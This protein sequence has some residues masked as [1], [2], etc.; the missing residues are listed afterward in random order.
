MPDLHKPRV[1]VVDD[2][3]LIREGVARAIRRRVPGAVVVPADTAPAAIAAVEREA[4]SM[5]VL[6]LGLPGGGGEWGT[7]QRLRELR[8]ALPILVLSMFPEEK[9]G[10]AAIERGASGY[11]CKTADRATVGE[12][13]LAVLAGRG[14]RSANLQSLLD[15]GGTSKAGGVAALSP[16]EL[17]VL[18]AL[19]QGD[20]N[21]EIA[22]RLGVGVTTVATYRA[23]IME[24]LKLNSAVELVRYVVE[25]RLV[26]K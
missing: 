2:H 20:A 24:K 19:G 13:A 17:E 8:P 3:A 6:D 1:L 12:A 10:V 21:K 15:A 23:R 14:Y 7:L 11:L 18:L 5:V 26:R 16:R 22:A 4:W 25:Q 9:M